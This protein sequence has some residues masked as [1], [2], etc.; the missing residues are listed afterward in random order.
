MAE[1]TAT[2]TGDAAADASRYRVAW[3]VIVAGKKEEPLLTYRHIQ[4]MPIIAYLPYLLPRPPQDSAIRACSPVAQIYRCLRCLSL[5]F[6]S[7]AAWPPQIPVYAAVR[8]VPR[9]LR[10][11]FIYR[12]PPKDDSTRT[13][14]HVMSLISEGLIEEKMPLMPRVYAEIGK[15]AAQVF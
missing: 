4:P 5:I 8:E 15:D 3:R 9:C 1:V 10:A 7:H 2:T 6:E 13:K 12:L 11:L 14:S